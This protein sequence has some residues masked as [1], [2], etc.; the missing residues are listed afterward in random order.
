VPIALSIGL[1]LSACQTDRER[2]K[3]AGERLGAV[4][5]KQQPEPSLPSDCRRRE[6]SGVQLEDPLD[7]ALLKTDQ[8]LGRA[9]DRVARCADWHDNYRGHMGR[10]NE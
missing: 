6:R 9:N 8:A 3:L 4:A 2:A 5:A 7:L 10:G 1:F